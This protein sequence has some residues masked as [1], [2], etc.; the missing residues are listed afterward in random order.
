MP[1]R[2]SRLQVRRGAVNIPPS[3]SRTTWSIRSS[4]C[5]AAAAAA[6]AARPRTSSTAPK[7]RRAAAQAG[8][9]THRRLVRPAVRRHRWTASPTATRAETAAASRLPALT[10]RMR[11]VAAA[12]D[13]RRGF[14]PVRTSTMAAARV[15]RVS[16]ATCSAKRFTSARVAAADMPILRMRLD[17][18]SPARADPALAAT[19]RTSRTERMPHP[20]SRI[21]ARAAAAEA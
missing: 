5:R 20:A 13:G 14:P 9:V 19:R 17:T 6:A 3:R 2:T 12:A 10:A 8:A 7:A 15:V 4:A 18:P 16:P 1:Q 11:A 21:P